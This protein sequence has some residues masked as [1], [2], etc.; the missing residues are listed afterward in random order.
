[1]TP[2]HDARADENQPAIVKAIRDRSGGEVQ[3]LHMVG[4]GCP[5][6]MVGLPGATIVGRFNWADLMKALEGVPNA[7]ML[8]GANVLIEIKTP[9]GKLNKNQED[10]H[11]D[12]PGQVAVARD[13][14][15]ALALCGLAVYRTEG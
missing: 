5:D 8:N 2:R 6:I 3:H 1:M 9:T 15:E 4:E 11:N 13:E 12:W 14:A 7:V 10:W